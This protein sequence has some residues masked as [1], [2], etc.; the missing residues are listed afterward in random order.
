L[1]IPPYRIS[2]PFKAVCA[3]ETGVRSNSRH[4]FDARCRGSSSLYPSGTFF[5]S[6]RPLSPSSSFSPFL[7]L[8]SVRF[9]TFLWQIFFPFRRSRKH[10]Y[11]SVH[12]GLLLLIPPQVVFLGIFCTPLDFFSTGKRIMLL[13]S[14]QTSSVNSLHGYVLVSLSPPPPLSF[15]FVLIPNTDANRHL[16]IVRVSYLPGVPY[17]SPYQAGLS[18]LLSP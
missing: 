3:P 5:S 18:P 17:M 6:V 14:P 10:N 2:F 4:D 13:L 15:L 12:G 9:P 16:T 11:C 1:P 7:A 8:G